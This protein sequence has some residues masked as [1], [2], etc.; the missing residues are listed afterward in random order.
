MKVYPDSDTFWAFAGRTFGL[1]SNVFELPTEEAA[2]QQSYPA[3]TKKK[4]QS[5][6]QSY[7]TIGEELDSKKRGR[8]RVI[9]V[10]DEEVLLSAEL[11]SD[12]DFLNWK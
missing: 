4:H 9:P 12:D 7:L 6:K 1:V 5:R 8:S 10:D 2:L 11:H 3:N